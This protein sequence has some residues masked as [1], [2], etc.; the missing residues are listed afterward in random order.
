MEAM[1]EPMD[2]DE[3][4]WHAINCVDGIH[5]KR[6]KD[7][8]AATIGALSALRTRLR[9]N[10]EAVQRGRDSLNEI[11]NGGVKQDSPDMWIRAIAALAALDEVLKEGT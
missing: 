4:L 5:T 7:Y 1:T 3:A 9:Q 10:R 11:I 6:P 2:V 8:D